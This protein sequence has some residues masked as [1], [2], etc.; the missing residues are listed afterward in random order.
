MVGLS[1]LCL[2]ATLVGLVNMDQVHGG[3][4]T[5]PEGSVFIPVERD[6]ERDREKMQKYPP[7]Y[8]SLISM[9]M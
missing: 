5:F 3:P 4:M 8:C 1:V 2:I 6:E 9:E 7:Q